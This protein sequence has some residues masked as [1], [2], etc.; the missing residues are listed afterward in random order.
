MKQHWKSYT[1]WTALCLTLVVLT[2][3]V[4]DDDA[5]E[6]PISLVNVGDPIPE[7]TLSGS[8]GTDVYSSALSGQVYILNFFD[9]GCPDCQEELQVLQRIYDKYHETVPVLNVPRS[10]S[11]EEV[12]AYWSEKGFSM[13]FFMSTDRE[14]Y[15]Q[16]ATRIIPR[17]YVVDG[18]G[19]ATA[20]FDD[21]PTADYD[22]LDA[23]LRQLLLAAA[24]SEDTVSLTLRM[25]VA[26]GNYIDEHFFQNEFVISQLEVWFFDA[27]TKKFVTKAAINNLVQG[28]SLADSQ[29]DIT[30][31]YEDVRLQV[32]LYDIFAIANY[33]Y[34]PESVEDEQ[35]FLNM[36]D[37]LTYK[38]GIEANM[39]VKGPVMTNR[40]TS[41]LAV[42]LVPWANKSYVLTVDME[43][44]MAKLQIGVSKNTFQLTHNQIKYA[45]I[46]ITNYKLVNLNSQYYLFQH[47]DSLTVFGLQPEFSL[48]KNFGDY[49]DIGEQYVVDPLFYQ[50]TLNPSDASQFQH[51]YQSWYGAFTTADFASM[52]S[53][54]NYGYAYIL[55]NTAFKT[56]QKNG[57]SP[58]IVFKAAVSPVFVYLYDTTL[59]TLKEEY[60]P[61]YWPK[62]IYLY[63][64]IFYG[65]IQAVN[66]ASG[67]ALDELETYTDAQ[68]KA[69]NIKQV[70]FN[71]GV[72]ETYY[73]Y[74]IRHR[75]S[76]VNTMGPMEY[77]IVRNNY[78]KM[79]VTGINGIG[80]S[81]ITPEIM[82]DNYPNSYSDMIINE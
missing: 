55:E 2:A 1:L 24:G 68:L 74:W 23:T 21:S 12:Q 9:T 13:P 20:A 5:D 45:D 79:V 56:C 29:Y 17:T 8:D 60:R 36:I 82:R 37:S 46:N 26:G 61:E 63:N 77:G 6:G 48:L 57:Y 52:P 34:S 70:K 76:V 47:K 65:S 33:D 31:I 43:R 49:A 72:Y 32:G 15:Y 54:A 22:T 41:L 50:K 53:A 7:F 11:E 14:L 58:G 10:Q 81:S 27:D 18:E 51:Y 59:R 67:L 3:C 42:D 69:Y 80:N 40:A 73:T 78:Y 25:K 30:Y 44:V 16:F 75:N 71:M 66:V 64:Y 35:E 19:K 38:D 62:T 39:P 28:P 4:D